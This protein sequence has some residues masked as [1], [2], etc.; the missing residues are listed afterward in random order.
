MLLETHSG[1]YIYT[2]LE[3]IKRMPRTQL[4][5]HLES[6]GYACYEEEPTELLRE[7]AIED[8]ESEV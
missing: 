4:V 5:D 2:T 3:M 1:S 6:R 8:W 7:T